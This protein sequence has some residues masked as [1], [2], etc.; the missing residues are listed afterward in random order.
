[1]AA[2][3]VAMND[4]FGNFFDVDPV[5]MFEPAAAAEMGPPRDLFVFDGQLHMIRDNN[6]RSGVTLR[7]TSQGPGPASTAVGITRNPYN[8][9]GFPDELGNPWTAWT[10]KLGQRRMSKPNTRW[11]S[12]SRMFSSTAR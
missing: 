10:D 5:E 1:M 3:F 9:M 12:S 4:V 2:A 11:C 8:P 6:T 7:A